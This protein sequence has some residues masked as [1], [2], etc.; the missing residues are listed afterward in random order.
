MKIKYI[1]NFLY[2]CLLTIRTFYTFQA[3][4][5]HILYFL[6]LIPNTRPIAFITFVWSQIMNFIYPNYRKIYRPRGYEMY[7]FEI[8]LHISPLFIIPYSISTSSLV[9]SISTLIIYIITHKHNI[10]WIYRNNRETMQKIW[11]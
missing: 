6:D 9:F 2:K 10:I 7:L 11:K 1:T 3:V 4:A 5:F 8:I